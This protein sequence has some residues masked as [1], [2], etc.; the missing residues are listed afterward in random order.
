MS[1]T[2]AP[3]P[4][5]TSTSQPQLSPPSRKFTPTST[6]IPL[7]PTS[8]A[9]LYH[10]IHPIL[11]LSLGYLSFPALV[12]DPV[13]TLFRLLF[14][15]AALQAVYCVLCLPIAQAGG[16]FPRGTTIGRR[17]K[18]IKPGERRR[19]GGGGEWVGKISPALLSLL[20]TLSLAAPV[21]LIMLILFGAPL[22][23]H[24]AHNLLCA[25]HMALLALMPLFYVYGVEAGMWREVCSASLPWDG[26][27][28]GTVG[29]VVGAW[30]GAVPIPLDW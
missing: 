17:R 11:V 24:F 16:A 20:L 4:S 18:N 21:L 30:L 23:T 27:W 6:P 29:T 10:H 7:L 1:T 12:A 19:D 13:S 25:T 3:S 28:G 9:H 14:P 5:S 8:T 2:T 26:V 15:V 22:T